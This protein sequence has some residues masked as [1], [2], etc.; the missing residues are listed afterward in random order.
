M[1][2]TIFIFFS[3]LSILT[4]CN[5]QTYNSNN[6]SEFLKRK[7]VIGDTVNELGSSIMVIYQDKKNNYWFGSWKTGVY[8]YDGKTLINY[9][10]KHGLYTDRV[11]DIKEDQSGNIYF[12]GMNPDATITKFDG[13]SLM[14]I[15]AIPS[16]EWKLEANDLWLK[17]PYQN[18]QKVYR[19]DETNLYEL[20]LPKPPQYNNPFD[21]YNIYKDRKGN[22]WFGTNPV[23]VCRYDGKS[24]EWITEEDLTEFRNEGQMEFAP[25]QKIKM[26]TFGSTPKI[27][28]VFTTVKP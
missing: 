17:I 16:N 22:I 23:G 15:K 25:L 14:K 5:G 10:T 27:D 9:T 20:S 21:V 2:L 13:E 1:N 8:K 11:D 24:F 19:F 26:A 3:I 28:I 6:H 7:N 12:S 4:S 18:L